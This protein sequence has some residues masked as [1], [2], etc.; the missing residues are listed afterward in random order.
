MQLQLI[1]FINFQ[2]KLMNGLVS[3][4]KLLKNYDNLLLYLC[5]KFHHIYYAAQ[6]V[7]VKQSCSQLHSSFRLVAS[8]VTTAANRGVTVVYRLVRQGIS[9]RLSLDRS[10]SIATLNHTRFYNT[11]HI[12]RHWHAGSYSMYMYIY[13]WL[14]FEKCKA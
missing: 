9:R 14:L 8:T 13:L 5:I 11:I 4:N 7:V 3:I 12:A 10:S 1:A 2:Y 6:L